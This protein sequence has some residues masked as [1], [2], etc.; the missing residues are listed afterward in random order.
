EADKHRRL[1]PDADKLE[2][3]KYKKFKR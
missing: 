2:R 1:G 3:I